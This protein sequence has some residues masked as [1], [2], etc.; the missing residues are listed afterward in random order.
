MKKILIVGFGDVAERLVHTYAGQAEFIGLVRRPERVADLRALGV[1]P[2]LGDLDDA[3]SLA[4]LPRVDAV[5]HFAPPPNA[6][7]TDPRTARLLAALGRRLPGALVYISTSGVYGD[8]GGDWVAETRPVAPVNGRAVR[9]VAAERQLRLWGRQHRVQV[10]ILRAP[11]I[12]AA[13]RLPLD[14]IKRGTPALVAE[15]DSYTNHIHADDLARLAWAALFRGRGQRLYHAVDAH[16]LKMADW[17]DSCADAFELPR[18]P[19]VKRAEAENVLS[20]AL[21]SFLRESRQL[22]NARTVRELKLKY[23]YPTSDD[24]LREVRRTRGQMDLF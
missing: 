15:D 18:P 10:S 4:R 14:R 6:G 17:F 2:Y 8:C 16:P 11:G 5:F 9:R 13:D 1:T 12:Y 23:R 22:S 3:A 21:L 24:L 20:E 7:A 19:R